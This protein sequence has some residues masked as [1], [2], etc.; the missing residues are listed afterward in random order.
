VLIV[1]DEPDI[2]EMLNE[3]LAPQGHRIDIAASGNEALG[4][5][6]ATDYDVILSDL[7]MPD[8]DGPGLYRQLQQ[9]YP[10]LL[11]RIVFITGDTLGIGAS[12]FLA[13]SGCPLIEKPFVPS[14]V[15]QVVRQVL[16]PTD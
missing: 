15:I 14:E 2:A 5:L 11:K 4:Y 10:H 7:K 3:L 8:L 1:D 16:N 6:E 13:Q 12:N 9:R